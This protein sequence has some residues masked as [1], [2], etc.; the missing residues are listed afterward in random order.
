M[1][2]G[3]DAIADCATGA[4]PHEIVAALVSAAEFG[5]CIG[6]VVS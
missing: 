4:S 1:R 3:L 6:E 2:Y 5:L